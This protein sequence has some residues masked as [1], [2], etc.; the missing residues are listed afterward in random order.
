M[1]LTNQA[2]Y[3]YAKKLSIFKNCNIKMPVRINFFLQKNILEIENASQEIENARMG[4]AAQF[5]SL[6]ED[7][8]AYDIPAEN[9]ALVNA[10]LL[11]LFSLEQ[12]IKIHVFK[13][14]DFEDIELTYQQMSA[15]LFMVE[16]E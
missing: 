13:I 12:D 8:T 15:I 10:E 9:A 6:N 5:G 16:E 14:S 4:I 1:K 11:E 2:I 3:E 7:G